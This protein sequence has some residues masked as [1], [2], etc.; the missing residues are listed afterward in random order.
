M[1]VYLSNDLLLDHL[2]K[3]DIFAIGVDNKKIN[4]HIPKEITL[5]MS[6]ER[7][8]R[9]ILGPYKY[10]LINSNNEFVYTFNL[11][12]IVFRKVGDVQCTLRI[13]DSNSEVKIVNFIF[14]NLYAVPSY[15][16][17]TD[18][19]LESVQADILNIYSILRTGGY[20]Q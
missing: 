10:E 20:N 17:E 12:N 8:D 1:E 7:P 3:C 16:D 11:Q 5:E 14:H 9:R 15:T 18:A 4:I 13:V 6:I 19:T 2:E